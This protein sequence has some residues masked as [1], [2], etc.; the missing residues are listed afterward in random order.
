MDQSGSRHLALKSPLIER[1]DL[2]SPRQRTLYGTLTLAFWVFW[3]YLW[4]PVL[5]LLAWTL[6][7][8]QAYKYMIVLG[9]YHD[10]IKLLGIYTLIIL[11]LGGALIL[12]AT[13]NIIRFRGVERR[14]APVPV[15]PTEIARDFDQDRNSVARWQSEQ[16]LYVTHDQEGNIA[17]V[18]IL[19]DGAAVPI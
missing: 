12:W 6:G 5:A 19:V 4:L 16:R 18:E 17:R 7:V 1:S 8:Q 14:I 11:L 2:Q 13:Y 15:T 9:G 10:V 3:V